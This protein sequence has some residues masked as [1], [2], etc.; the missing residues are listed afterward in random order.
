MIFPDRLLT[1][2]VQMRIYERIRRRI[3]ELNPMAEEKTIRRF[4]TG[5]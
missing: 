4:V 1:S 5:K 2:E 3:L